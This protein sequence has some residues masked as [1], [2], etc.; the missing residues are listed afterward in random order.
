VILEARGE[1]EAAQAAE[2]RAKLA[3]F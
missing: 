2:I 1:D 3:T